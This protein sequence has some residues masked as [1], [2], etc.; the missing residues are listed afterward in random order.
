MFLFCFLSSA[1]FRRC[2]GNC[3]FLCDFSVRCE[4]NWVEN[5]TSIGDRMKDIGDNLWIEIDILC[6][7]SIIS[8]IKR[9]FNVAWEIHNKH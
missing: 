7:L 8:E 4:R 2:E 3:C 1:D 6:V 5:R 9:N